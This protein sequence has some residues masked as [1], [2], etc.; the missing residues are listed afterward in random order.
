V[1]LSPDPPGKFAPELWFSRGEKYLP[2][3]LFFNGQD[4]RNNKESYDKLSGAEKKR[5]LLCY[6]RIVE[7]QEYVAYEYWYYYAYNEYPLIPGKISWLRRLLH[8]RFEP[9]LADNHEHDLEYAII[10]VEKSSGKPKVLCLNQHF[11]HNFVVIDAGVPPIKAE[12]G[13]HG[14][15]CTPKGWEKWEEG[16]EKMTPEPK[17][18]LE[19]LRSQFVSAERSDLLDPSGKLIG[20]NYDPLEIGKVSA[21]TIP[22]VRTSEY[23]FPEASVLGKVHRVK[24]TPFPSY[25]QEIPSPIERLGSISLPHSAETLESNIHLARR[26]NLLGPKE[27]DI[28]KRFRQL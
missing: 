12:L 16:G 5:N 17:V 24:G 21:P 22:W 7:G 15:F 10:Y 8:S 2:C 14:M 20:T 13:G 23:Y 11:W 3:D 4:I 19:A 1:S 26:L 18:D 25:S 27:E 6:Y 9:T 28:L